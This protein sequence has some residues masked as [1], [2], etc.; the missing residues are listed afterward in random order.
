MRRPARDGDN[1]MTH[2]FELHVADAR[3]ALRDAPVPRPDRRTGWMPLVPGLGLSV[4]PAA[5]L[6]LEVRPGNP[7]DPA[8]RIATTVRRA[9]DWLT[10]SLGLGE[11]RLAPGE[12]LGLAVEIEGC[13]D[14]R[15]G[16]FLRVARD[17]RTRDSDLD[18]VLAGCTG[19]EPRVLLHRVRDHDAFAGVAGYHSLILRLPTARFSLTLHDM[20]LFVLP[21]PAPAAA[22]PGAGAAA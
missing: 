10:L 13:P 3:A 6:D 21:C 15:I 7:P 19:R 17:S 14:H 16:A 11:G 18:G 5:D 9:P 20:R 22:A 2:P 12:T 4:D 1:A 8:L